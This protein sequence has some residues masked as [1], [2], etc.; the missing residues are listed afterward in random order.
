MGRFGDMLCYLVGSQ[1][2][3]DDL[4]HIKAIRQFYAPGQLIGQPH[5]GDQRTKSQS[6]P[7]H[8]TKA[9]QAGTG[10]FG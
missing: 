8:R 6:L 3:S 5:T 7:N 2:W 10:F 1:I 4:E 9:T